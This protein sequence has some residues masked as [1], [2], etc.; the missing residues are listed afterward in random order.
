MDEEGITDEMKD[1]FDEKC[2][3]LVVTSPTVTKPPKKS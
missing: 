1:I 3:R 2:E